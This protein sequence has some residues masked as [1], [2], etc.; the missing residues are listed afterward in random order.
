MAFPGRM[1]FANANIKYIGTGVE[2]S[3]EIKTQ[4]LDMM[5]ACRS[6]IGGIDMILSSLEAGISF[7]DWTD[8][9]GKQ[10]ILLLIIHT[11]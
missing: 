5:N 6:D 1:S 7:N 8:P 2:P 9:T 4:A 10:D 3:M 11:I